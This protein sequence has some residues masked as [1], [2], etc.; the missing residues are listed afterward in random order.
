MIS[1]QVQ[2]AGAINAV[3]LL[4]F[5]CGLVNSSVQSR[6]PCVH[7][8]PVKPSVLTPEPVFPVEQSPYANC[9]TN[10]TQLEKALIETDNNRYDIIKAF[11]PPRKKPSIY[12]D[13]KYK[14]GDG[15]N[16]IIE[17]W[18]WATTYFYFIQPPSLFVF[19]SLVFSYP[20]EQTQSLSLSLP[21]ECSINE[22]TTTSKCRQN[23]MLD[24]LTQRV[25]NIGSF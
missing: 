21:A 2:D 25:C 7:C 3:L 10:F 15:D 17:N 19:T 22:S 6:I 9:T 5:S 12:V 13:V 24:V 14:F 18:I 8:H 23:P 4:L 11:Y 20:T 1:R 16:Q